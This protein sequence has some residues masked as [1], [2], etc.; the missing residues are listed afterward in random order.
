MPVQQLST[1]ELPASRGYLDLELLKHVESVQVLGKFGAQKIQPR[2]KTATT[3]FSR[4]TPYNASAVG[5]PQ[6]TATSFRL[7]EGTPPNAHQLQYT[8]VYG[9][10]SH[11]G[12]LMR[13]TDE[14]AAL[15][16]LDVPEDMKK[17]VGDTLGEV[18]E[19]VAYGQL[20]GGTSV[21]RANGST[22]AAINTTITLDHLRLAMRT[23]KANR[24]KLVT[25]A[26][27]PGPNFGT[28][29][30]QASMPV[31]HH[32][33][34][35]ADIQRLAGYVSIVNYG[36]AIKPIHENEH[37]YCQGFRFIE[38]PV[39]GPFLAQGATVG[40]TGMVAADSTNVDVYP[41]IVMAEDAWGHISLKGEKNAYTGIDPTVIPPN[42]KSKSDPLGQNGFVGAGA[43]YGCIRTNENW[44]IRIEACASA[45]T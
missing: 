40:G 8:N 30:I 31:F 20:R 9:T 11:Y 4:V 44:M 2:N 14:T 17:Q 28:S 39:L 34:M 36:T 35:T 43:W 3:I 7:T 6:I 25:K 10:V 24:G 38:S 16:E 18:I 13:W 33:D 45:L 29:A 26:I 12:Y 5:V 37:G 1:F 22:R 27:N 15:H 21:I 32:T 41:L 42:Q 23:I 19:L